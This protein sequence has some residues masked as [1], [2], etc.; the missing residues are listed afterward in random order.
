M[1][2]DHFL[3]FEGR[4]RLHESNKTF[5]RFSLGVD[6]YINVT[7]NIIPIKTKLLRYGN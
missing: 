3:L 6:F 1:D 5:Y 7:V 4:L 2:G